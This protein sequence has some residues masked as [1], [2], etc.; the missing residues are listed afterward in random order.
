MNNDEEGKRKVLAELMRDMDISEVM[1]VYIMSNRGYSRRLLRFFRWLSKWMPL[2]I[3]FA[4]AYGLW[5]FSQ[6]PR[7][8]FVLQQGNTACYLFI[9]GMVYILPMVLVLSSRFFWLCWRYRIPFFYYLGVNSI[10]I[11]YGSLFTT[12]EMVASHECLFIMI[13]GFYGYGFVTEFLKRSTIGRR[14]CG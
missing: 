1:N 9:Y 3:M 11:G 12:N 14:I 2:I 8:L 13:L 6:H 7:E 4:H 10:H 5:R